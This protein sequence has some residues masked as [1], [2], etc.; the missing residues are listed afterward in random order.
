MYIIME[1]VNVTQQ[2]K[3]IN[4]VVKVKRDIQNNVKNCIITNYN[5]FKRINNFKNLQDL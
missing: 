1:K 2:N 5:M 4:H 3:P